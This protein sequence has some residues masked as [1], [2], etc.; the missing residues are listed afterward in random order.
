MRV[1]SSYV[2][3][4]SFAMRIDSERS[5]S[6]L[7]GAARH[8][9]HVVGYYFSLSKIHRFRSQVFTSTGQEGFDDSVRT[10][11]LPELS[12]QEGFNNSVRTSN[13][14]NCRKQS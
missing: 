8:R 7:P 13:P 4:G 2:V 5:R 10:S 9:L 14:R 12:G 6:V 3:F 11:S 1:C